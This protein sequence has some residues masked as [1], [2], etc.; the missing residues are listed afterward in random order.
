[1]YKYKNPGAKRPDFYQAK[2]VQYCAHGVFADAKVKIA[3]GKIF[4]REIASALLRDTG[5]R[6]GSEVCGSPDQPGNVL[7]GCIQHLGRRLASCQA[8]RIG[9]ELGKVGGPAL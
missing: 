9:C 5:F 3:S 1:M 4:R 7:G 8:L 6:G 2:P